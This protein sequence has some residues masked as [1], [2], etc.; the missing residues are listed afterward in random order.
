MA[1]MND[2]FSAIIGEYVKHGGRLLATWETG[3]YSDDG[4]M[5]NGFALAE[6]LGLKY[7]GVHPHSTTYAE[8]DIEAVVCIGKAVKVQLA[9]A[10]TLLRMVGPAMETSVTYTKELPPGELTDWPLLTVNDYGRGQ[11]MYLG[12]PMGEF[13]YRVG[14]YRNKLFLAQTIDRIL[15]SR[16]LE[17]DAP[18]TVEVSVLDQPALGRRTVFLINKTCNA[19]YPAQQLG[20]SIDLII[21]VH[22]VK[23]RMP[24]PNERVTVSARRGEIEISRKGLAM[25][26]NVKKLEFYEALVFDG[27]FA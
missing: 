1:L 12:C 24:V 8:D 25:E 7:A 19:P 11:A 10:R 21:P 4:V 3:L 27:F 26:V 14:Y 16:I 22:D 20:S 23:V 13:A 9:G 18:Y 2:E 15:P 17:V 5:R 6:V